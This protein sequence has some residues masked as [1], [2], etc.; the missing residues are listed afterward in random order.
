MAINLYEQ[1]IM[2]VVDLDSD[3]IV[4]VPGYA[5]K[6]PGEPTLVNSSNFTAI[7]GDAPYTFPADQTALVDKNKALKNSKEKSW[8]YAKGLTDAGLTVLYHRFKPSSAP[9]PKVE[10]GFSVVDASNSAISISYTLCA[11]SKY[12]GLYYKGLVVVFT[13]LSGGVSKVEVKTSTLAS[14]TILESHTFTF[15]PSSNNYLANIE[16]SNI[17]LYGGKYELTTDTEINS[18]KT[19]YTRTGSGTAQSPYVYTKVDTPVVGSLNS[20]YERYDISILDF[21]ENVIAAAP[22]YQAYITGSGTLTDSATTD[23]FTVQ[24]FETELKTGA[25]TYKILEDTETYPVTYITTGGYFVQAG[26]SSP[27]SPAGILNLASGIKAAAAIDY[28]NA[29]ANA[30]GFETYKADAIALGGVTDSLNYS[31]GFQVLG[32][33]TF[34]ADGSRILLPDSYGYFVKLG[35]NVSNGIPTWIPVANNANGIVSAGIAATRPVDFA[36]ESVMISNIGAS[37]NPIIKKK[38]VG[39]VIMGNRTLYPNQ[40]VLGPQS[41]LNCRLVV[42]AIERSARTSA[43]KLRIVSTN[44]DTAFKTFKND[45]SK[46]AD[47]YLTAGDGLAEYNIMLLPKTKPATIDIRIQLT[48][49]EG[50]ET[51]NIYIPYSIALD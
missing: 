33:D 8:I 10:A 18:T 48:V 15:N 16:F 12:F 36:L 13:K 43:N 46:T 32:C 20:Y 14:A 49:V 19:Y 31:F 6:G 37:I 44:R 1:P 27:L 39:Y 41:F 21:C 42:N 22:T 38:N 17:E 29:L 51:F 35:T 47:K 7:F 9:V 4:Y 30:S 26:S 34:N 5:I 24:D 45:V 3:V 11:R 23:G 28:A 50:I 2:P 25:N 40:G